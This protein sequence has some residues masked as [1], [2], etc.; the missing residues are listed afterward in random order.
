MSELGNHLWQSTLFAAVVAAICVALRK[1]QARTRYWLWLAAS[2]KFLIPFSLLVSMGGRMAVPAS[3]PVVPGV[4]AIRV[5]QIS[6]SFAPMP[7]MRPVRAIHSSAPWWPEALGIL[8]LAGT[9][10]V[11][12][13]WI[14]RWRELRAVQQHAKPATLDFPIPVAVSPV[15][16]E[17]GVFGFFRP[18]LLLP[19]GLSEKL[20]PEQFESVLAHELCHVR[21]HDNLTAALHLGV[22]TIFWFHPAVWWIGRRLIEERERACDEAVLNQGSRP[23]AYA[24]GI[25]NICKFYRESP[26]PCASGVTGA[27]LKQRIR[28]IMTRRVAVRLTVARKSLLAVAGA[29]VVTVPLAIGVLRAQTLPPAPKYGYEV[30]SVKRSAPDQTNSR[31]RPGA[32]GGIRTENT[33][34]MALLT[35]AYDVRDYQ[36]VDAPGWVT[37][38]RY[39]V[40]FTPDKPE[41]AASPTTPRDQ[42]EGQFRR[43]QQRMQAVLRDRFGL[44]LRAETREMP[45]YV[46]TVGKNGHK[47]LPPKEEHAFPHMS[48]SPDEITGTNLD[49]RFLTNGLANLMGRYVR[50]E[51]GLKG[52][53]D[54]KMKWT[55]DSSQRLGAPRSDEPANTDDPGSGSIF[56]ALQEQLGL[57]LEAKKGPVPV[58]V[59]EKIQRPSEN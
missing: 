16:L 10:L 40:S 56:M 46:L 42:M 5:E 51:T 18:V 21:S 57:K 8:W 55:P 39:D 30:A 17:P 28:E 44:V 23:E 20:A 45:V 54:F 9:V 32:Q 12:A 59:V 38:E 47:L 27:D 36:F 41:E 37:S 53:Y 29:I 50:D 22:S 2:T 52:V 26:L 24:Q 31:I 48:T 4:H 58:F 33:S 34:V 6:S 14:R 13:S 49:L 3:K 19:E 15:A 11:S 25:L 7:A 43:Q 35:F 1:N